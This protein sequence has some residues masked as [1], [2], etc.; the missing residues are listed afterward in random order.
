MYK[1]NHRTAFPQVLTWGVERAP[2]T[3]IWKT[4]RLWRSLL[5]MR[6]ATSFALLAFSFIGIGVGQTGS[7]PQQ[8]STITDR[9]A[10]ITVMHLYEQVV[11]RKPLGIPREADRKAIWPFLSHGLVRRLE[12]AQACEGD[13][14][15]QHSGE[16]GKPEFV[17]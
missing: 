10:R 1:R 16:N 4:H 13:Y 7:P 15:R 2:T 9:K 5:G 17:W 8:R 11:L 14:Y 3:G 12:S 6:H